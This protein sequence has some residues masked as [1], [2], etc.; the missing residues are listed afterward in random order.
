MKWN[1]IKCTIIWSKNDDDFLPF[2]ILLSWANG[3]QYLMI[4]SLGNDTIIMEN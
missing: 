1:G 2:I 4:S 3:A